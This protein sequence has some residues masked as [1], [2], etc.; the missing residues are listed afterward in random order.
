MR[1]LRTVPRADRHRAR[2]DGASARTRSCCNTS[3]RWRSTRWRCRAKYAA[4]PPGRPVPF[5]AGHGQGAGAP[6]SASPV[7]EIRYRCAGINHMAFYL[8]FE[9]RLPDGSMEDLYPRIRQ[10]DRATKPREPATGTRCATRCSAHFGYFVT[11][12]LG[13]FRRIRAVVHQARPARPDR[14]VQHPARRIYP[15]LRGADRALGQRRRR[16]S[17]PTPGSRWR[18]ARNMRPASSLPK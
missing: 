18:A 17:P 2:H 12:I 6:T 11:E 14:E 5:G 16:S 7:E 3:T 13:A 9:R 8:K 1:G 10:G 4:D 15:P